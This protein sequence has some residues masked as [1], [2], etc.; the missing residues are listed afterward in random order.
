MVRA[1]RAGERTPQQLAAVRQRGGKPSFAERI[2]ALTGRWDDT[3]IVSLTQ[4]LELFEY[5]TSTSI[6]C[7]GHGE[8]QERARESG[9]EPAAPVPNLPPAKGEST[10]KTALTWNAR[11]QSAG[12]IGGDL[13]A[14]LG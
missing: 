2:Q 4:A 14:A 3:Q 13:V 12:V 1:I 9:W 11:A 7:A 8:Q 10:A 6:D 5:S